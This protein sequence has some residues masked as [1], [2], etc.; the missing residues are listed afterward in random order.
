MSR[1]EQDGVSA[2]EAERDKV[3]VLEQALWQRLADAPDLGGFAQAWLTLLCRR[4]PGTERGAIVL[5]PGQD[6][7]P[8]ALWPEAAPPTPGLA[9][10]IE[11]ALDTRRGT[12][13][14]EPHLVDSAPRAA[15]VSFP[16][17]MGD[18]VGGAVG[19]ELRGADEARLRDVMRQLQWGA[20]W[21]RERLRQRQADDE[22]RAGE[23]GR[24]ALELI[25]A[26]AEDPEFGMASRRAATELA[27]RFGCD[28]VSI[29]FVE[30]T[31]TRVVAIS[32]SA[33]VERRMSLVR[34]LGAAMDEAVDQRA[35]LLFPP[36]EDQLYALAAHQELAEA[37]GSTVLTV[38]LLQHD[39]FIGAVTFERPADA[40]FDERTVVA[41]DAVAGVLGPLLIEKRRNDRWIGTKLAEALATQTKRLLGP[42]YFG[43]KL[44]ALALAAL[45][46]AAYFATGRYTVT[47]QAQLEGTVRRAVVAGF[48]GYLREAPARAGDVVPEG[49]LLASLDDRDLAFERLRWV[50][51]R[52]QKLQEYERAMGARDR[53]AANIVRSQ[54]EQSEAQIQLVDVQLARTRLLAP[55]DGIVVSGDHTQSIGAAVK[56]GDILFEVAPLNSYR[57]VMSVDEAKVADLEVGQRGTLITTAL[58]YD[59][60][61]FVVTK[62]M[63][64]VE[65][66]DGHT[67]FRVEATLEGDSSSVRPGMKGIAKIDVDERR[68]VWI[69]THTLIDYFRLIAWSW[70][71]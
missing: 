67:V 12:V 2:A 41:L 8:A 14:F 37:H 42:A 3:A 23:R 25:A 64:V 38:P 29:G 32:H 49:N 22:R 50:T 70:L 61:P 5:G 46:A 69:W 21:I 36:G 35:S 17:I 51:D 59:P 15:A 33:A 62:V 11:T 60:F 18:Q 68:L 13:R 54:I 45:L 24:I 39:H 48:D 52:Q 31:R 19:I 57:V 65:V 63:P 16:I 30:R 43:R 6:Y 7:A 26:V 47:A 58:P 9:A 28:R 40:P 1:L 55:F 66:L 34:R 53:A 27:L 56:R 71:G 4:V 10:V 44:A 20:G